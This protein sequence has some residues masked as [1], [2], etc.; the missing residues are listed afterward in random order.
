MSAT[1]P[2]RTASNGAD[3]VTASFAFPP[4][5]QSVAALNAQAASA[6]RAGLDIMEANL[7]AF[8]GFMDTWRESARRQQDAFFSTVRTQ[9]AGGA[10]ATDKIDQSTDASAGLGLY[11][12][13]FLAATK[14]YENIGAA[15][16]S[17]QR[18]AVEALNGQTHIR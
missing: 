5:L 14:A 8:R 18:Q 13:P 10:E 16:I 7:G 12:A 17:A 2:R 6:A 3:A 11:F 9:I 15:V 4:P 1:R